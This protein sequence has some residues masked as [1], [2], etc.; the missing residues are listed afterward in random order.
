M[1]LA[2]QYSVIVQSPILAIRT[3]WRDEMEMRNVQRGRIFG[4]GPT[5]TTRVGLIWN[6]DTLDWQ[7]KPRRKN[8]PGETHRSMRPVVM[9][10]DVVKIASILEH[11]I[12]PVQLAQ[13]PRTGSAPGIAIG[14]PDSQVDRGISVSDGAKVAL[15]V[16]DVHRI[17][18]DL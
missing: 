3:P 18:P 15:E 11:R 2:L 13:P 4:I 12:V 17:E 9:C 6:E 10:L 16:T 8:N 5:G 7:K 14:T 1:Y